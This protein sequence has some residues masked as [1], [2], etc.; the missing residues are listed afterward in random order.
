MGSQKSPDGLYEKTTFYFTFTQNEFFKNKELKSTIYISNDEVDKSEG[1]VIE[2]TLN[3][4]QTISKKRQRNKNTGEYRLVE[5][6]KQLKSFFQIFE[7]FNDAE[8][9]DSVDDAEKQEENMNLFLLDDL[10]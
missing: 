9:M 4:T 1:T 10:F 2:W 8:E 3:P 6:K 5:K 7:N